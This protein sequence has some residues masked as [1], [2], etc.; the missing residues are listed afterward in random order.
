M[1]SPFPFDNWIC[2][3]MATDWAFAAAFRAGSDAEGVLTNTL[4]IVTASRWTLTAQT[5]GHLKIKPAFWT[6]FWT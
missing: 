1:R 5:I 4:V 6:R 3:W 2:G